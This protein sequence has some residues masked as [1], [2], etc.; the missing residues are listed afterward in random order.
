VYYTPSHRSRHAGSAVDLADFIDTMTLPMHHFV[1]HKSD[2]NSPLFA[3]RMPFE[4]DVE[5][6]VQALD[7]DAITRAL[8]NVAR[9]NMISM[10]FMFG[11]YLCEIPLVHGKFE[12]WKLLFDKYRPHV[13]CWESAVL[14][15]AVFHDKVRLIL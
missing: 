12:F 8:D 14:A 1:R 5:R 6:S 10:E 3:F 7:E 15:E 2:A 11:A 4:E 9:F 13:K